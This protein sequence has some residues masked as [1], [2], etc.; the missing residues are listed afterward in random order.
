MSYILD[1]LRKAERER[2]I[3][4]VPNLMT[5]HT[6]RSMNRGRIWAVFS[7]VAICVAASVWYFVPSRT[8][9]AAGPAD[10]ELNLPAVSGPGDGAQA[11]V[12]PLPAPSAPEIQ[13]SSQ[14]PAGT[15]VAPSAQSI[16]IP[17]GIAAQNLIEIRQREN[18]QTE[19]EDWVIPNEEDEMG[20]PPDERRGNLQQMQINPPRNE[21]AKAEPESLQDAI[22]EMMLSL[23]MF[24]DAKEERM[25]FINGIKYVEGDRIDGKYLLE[26][27]TIDGA[28]L[29]YQGESALLKPK[30]K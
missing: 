14:K 26:S 29:S 13:P 9:S 15:A 6:P 21:T 12:S 2:G 10:R 3:R 11:S 22:G 1:A 20:M 18:R 8:E 25:V 5:D 23:L 30:S 4:Q 7:I 27:I 16:T 19:E 17:G 24:A 28:V